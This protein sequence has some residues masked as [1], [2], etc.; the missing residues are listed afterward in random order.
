MAAVGAWLDSIPSVE[1]GRIKIVQRRSDVDLGPVTAG[2]KCVVEHTTET[3]HIDLAFSRGMPSFAV[4][5]TLE[6]R[7]IIAQH[8][9]L[10]HACTALANDPTPGETNR[11]VGAQIENGGH[12]ALD[13]WTFPD[14]HEVLLA[15]LY[16]FFAEE[17]GWPKSRPFADVLDPNV[18]WATNNP[19]RRRAQ[20][21]GMWGNPEH[22]GLW[23]HV[24]VV[25]QSPS[26]HWDSGSQLSRVQLRMS[27]PPR[28]VRA[29]QVVATW[30]DDDGHFH[31]RPLSPHFDDRKDCPLWLASE[32]RQ[33][34][35]SLDDDG[36]RR[37][38]AKVVRHMAAGHEI[39]TI[40]RKVEES[41]LER[42]E[43]RDPEEEDV[44]RPD[45]R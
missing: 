28:M 8:V 7:F 13:P 5:K 9:P 6:G 23:K 3:D 45:G 1:G 34:K 36:D 16:D 39:K 22:S 40:E 18:V 32:I 14:P 4:G 12:A 33:W 29:F 11:V 27:E 10:W 42:G 38:A 26:W 2:W 17:L 19:R 15:S 35:G 21:Q 41:T 25:Q 44:Q 30:R 24:E 37:P 43:W 31:N 20:Q